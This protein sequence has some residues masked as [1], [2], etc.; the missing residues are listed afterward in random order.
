MNYLKKNSEAIEEALIG[1]LEHLVS[2][3]RMFYCGEN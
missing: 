3:A 1:P 2:T